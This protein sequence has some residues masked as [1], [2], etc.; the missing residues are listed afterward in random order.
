ML[1]AGELDD[2]FRLAAGFVATDLLLHG[3]E[4]IVFRIDEHDGARGDPVG[5]PLGLV[6]PA[7]LGALEVVVLHVVCVFLVVLLDDLERMGVAE[8]DLG[9]RHG[10]RLAGGDALSGR[11]P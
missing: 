11:H 6:A 10:G 9:Q 3:N 1:R 2:L 8:H 4:E 5:H 7:G